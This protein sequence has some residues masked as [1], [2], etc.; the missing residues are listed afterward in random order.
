[1]PA[2]TP[3]QPQ[4][5]DTQT[6]IQTQIQTVKETQH[7]TVKETPQQTTSK[8]PSPPPT[9]PTSASVTATGATQTTGG[10]TPTSVSTK[11]PGSG[12]SP[13]SAAPS[14]SQVSV[15]GS[16]SV[17][18]S[19]TETFTR[20][21]SPQTSM[22][23]GQQVTVV[24]VID[25]NTMSAATST[26]TSLP[27]SGA[28]SDRN[29]NTLIGGVVGGVIGGVLAA[30]LLVMFI[31]TMRRR[32]LAEKRRQTVDF[33]KTLPFIPADRPLTQYRT[34][35][36]ALLGDAFHACQR[37]HSS[38]IAE[39]NAP[40][41]WRCPTFALLGVEARPGPRPEYRHS[42]QR[43][44]STRWQNCRFFNCWGSVTGGCTSARCPRRGYHRSRRPRQC[45]HQQRHWVMC[46]LF[47]V[48]PS[49]TYCSG[50]DRRRRTSTCPR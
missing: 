7:E 18:V 5:K 36:A 6:V 13:T 15:S 44:H 34:Q 9:S 26:A 24:S 20:V 12:T 38:R 2:T 1:V 50:K 48:G 46:W 39:V 8:Q 31:L 41:G 40:R 4:T 21:F 35:A 10:Q 23:N 30:I 25:L 37:R 3:N 32:R 42:H 28:V 29:R 45:R 16:T 14:R 49:R 47:Y 22:S 43:S 33:G 27:A 19:G 11:P 17:F